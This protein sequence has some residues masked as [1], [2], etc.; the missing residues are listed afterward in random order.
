MLFQGTEYV[1]FAE[2]L[3]DGEDFRFSKSLLLWRSLLPTN[4]PVWTQKYTRTNKL[5]CMCT[6]TQ[7]Q[8]HI[9]T[10]TQTCKRAAAVANF[11]STDLLWF[12]P[13]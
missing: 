3:S 8:V 7:T 2:G 9:Y 10:H 11:T 6:S 5:M 13:P 12:A 4:L 1:Y